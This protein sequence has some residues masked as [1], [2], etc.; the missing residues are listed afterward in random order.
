MGIIKKIDFL[1]EEAHFTFNKYGDKGLKTIFGGIISTIAILL[2]AFISFYF[3]IRLIFQKDATVIFSSKQDTNFNLLYSYKL[4]ILFRISDRVSV[5]LKDYNLYELKLN[6]WYTTSNLSDVHHYQNLTFKKCNVYEH[7]NEYKKYFIHNEDLETF[8]CIDNRD[9]N[10]TLFGAYGDNNPF[11]YIQFEFYICNNDTMNNQCLSKEMIQKILDDAYLDLRYIN[12][13]VE[14]NKKNVKSISVKSERVPV[15]YSVYKRLWINFKAIEFISDNGIIFSRN[16]EEIFHQFHSLRLDT[17]LRNLENGTVPGNFFSITFALT[18]EI[19]IFNKYYSKL[20]NSLA[21][22]GGL[23]KTITFLARMLNY[24]NAKNSYYKKIVKDFLIENNIVKKDKSLTINKSE[25]KISNIFNNSSFQLNIKE[26]QKNIIKS[27]ESKLKNKDV[28][29]NKFKN[30][31][32][33]FRLSSLKNN[34]MKW[35]IQV[36]NNKM[37]II[38]ILNVLE[39]YNKLKGL[40]QNRNNNTIN[41]IN[42]ISGNIIYKNNFLIN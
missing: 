36:I 38:Y 23:I 15:S 29:K 5:P 30:S 27:L 14:S 16:S 13:N 22:I 9:E 28:F 19:S 2:S 4:P 32:F 35:Y 40:F 41:K 21:T 6:Y 3:L 37:N 26:S 34:E 10:L 24:Y 1:Y 17:D 20:Q 31:F 25:Q 42:T 33:P 18:G 8:F 11:S 39:G 7:F 12:Y